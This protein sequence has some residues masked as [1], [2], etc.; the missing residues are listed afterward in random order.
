MKLNQILGV[1]FKNKYKI[2]K[3]IHYNIHIVK[4]IKLLI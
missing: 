4:L 3:I 1:I 2:E